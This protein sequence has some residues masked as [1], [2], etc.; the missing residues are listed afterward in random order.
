MYIYQ[1][2]QNI[3]P[4]S[5][6]HTHQL[7]QH[8]TVGATLAIVRISPDLTL[9]FNVLLKMNID[10]LKADRYSNT[11]LLPLRCDA[12]KCSPMPRDVKSPIDLCIDPLYRIFICHNIRNIIRIFIFYGVSVHMPLWSWPVIITAGQSI[13]RQPFIQRKSD[14]YVCIV[15][16]SI[17]KFHVGVE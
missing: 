10:D 7:L 8:R 4:R 3:S 6:Q 12:D 5:T 2:I 17:Y 14:P 13:S 1:F 9:Y 16:F 15:Y 11:A